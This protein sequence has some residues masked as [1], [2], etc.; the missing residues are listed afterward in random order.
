MPPS[1]RDAA[2]L[3]DMLTAAEKV[4]RYLRGRTF[5]EYLDDELLRDAVERNILT[6]GEAARGV[7]V[8]L[9]PHFSPGAQVPKGR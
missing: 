5:E 8:T 6:I 9:S 3:L 4:T 2:F 7:S 1:E